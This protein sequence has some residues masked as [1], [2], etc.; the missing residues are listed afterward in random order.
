MSRGFSSV[1]VLT[2]IN[3]V[4]DMY[5]R[6]TGS[7]SKNASSSCGYTLVYIQQQQCHGH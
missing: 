5:P 2:Q 4:P 3:E 1:A 6:E 7:D